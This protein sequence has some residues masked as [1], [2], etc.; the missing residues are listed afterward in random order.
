ME[1][2]YKISIRVLRDTHIELISIV[3]TEYMNKFLSMELNIY[4][5]NMFNKYGEFITTIN[6]VVLLSTN[7]EDINVVRK[8]GLEST[9]DIFKM[10]VVDFHYDLYDIEHNYNDTVYTIIDKLIKKDKADDNG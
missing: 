1:G 4:F 9:L 8:L 5:G 10:S 7:K 6:N 2:I 3:D